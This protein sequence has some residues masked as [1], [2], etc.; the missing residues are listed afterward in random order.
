MANE[1]F[2]FSVSEYATL[3]LHHR[4]LYSL[5]SNL[6]NTCNI[7]QNYIKKY[8]ACTISWIRNFGM[9]KSLKSSNNNKSLRSS[10]N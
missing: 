3:N 6:K 4:I 1:L 5:G 10:N 7:A 2:S 8:L 9:I